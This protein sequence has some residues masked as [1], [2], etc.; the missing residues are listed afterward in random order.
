MRFTAST[1]RRLLVFGGRLVGTVLGVEAAVGELKAL[2]RTAVEEM[3]V[4]NLRDV[5]HMDEAV[6]DGIRIDDHDG[7]VLALV[8][9]AG[10]VRADLALQAGVFNRIF[11]GAFEFP[12]AVAGTTGAGSVF[13]PLVGAD[14]EVMLEL[15]H[16]WVSS[17]GWPLGIGLPCGAHR[18]LRQ[19]ESDAI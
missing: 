1:C 9:A 14:K 17:R 18:F 16:S 4:D 10:F 2:D 3:L 7:A 8:K 5:F 19:Y 12:A 11:E 13:V 6:P 15:C